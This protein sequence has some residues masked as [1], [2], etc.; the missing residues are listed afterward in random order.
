[1]FVL[2]SPNDRLIE[3]CIFLSVEIAIKFLHTHFNTDKEKLVS[4]KVQ[5][6]FSSSY[7]YI[8]TVDYTVDNVLQ[9]SLYNLPK[10][11]NY[12]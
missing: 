7:G 12:V 11:K 5:R 1:M 2:T 10:L 6:A 9:Q 3:S 8:I 4:L